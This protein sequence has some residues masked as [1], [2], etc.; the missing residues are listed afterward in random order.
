MAIILSVV[1]LSLS[2]I[3]FGV[4]FFST[5]GAGLYRIVVNYLVPD[6]PDKKYSWVD[7]IY[8]DDTY[9]VSGF[10]AGGDE[11]S[12]KIWTLSGLKRFYAKPKF[13]SFSF[14]D[15]CA[16]V[17]QIQENGLKQA[18]NNESI[19]FDISEFQA[20]LKPEY[21]VTVWPVGKEDGKVMIDKVFAFSGKYKVLGRVEQGVCD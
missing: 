8:K 10:Y 15:T 12:I 13:S 6:L 4:Y 5:G 18:I 21:F 7:F 16:A 3:F 1:V 2:L 20:L 9:K 17:R 14:R 11:E 19:N